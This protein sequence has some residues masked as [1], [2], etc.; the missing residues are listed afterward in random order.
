MN[1]RTRRL[2]RDESGDRGVVPGEQVFGIGPPA[3]NVI[4]AGVEGEDVRSQGVGRRDL[5]GNHLVKEFAA[6]GE[7]RVGDRSRQSGRDAIGP[8]QVLTV[9]AGLIA[10]TFG[11][12]VAETYASASDPR[13]VVLHLRRTARSGQPARLH[14]ARTS[15][16]Y[17]S[18]ATRWPSSPSPR[19]PCRSRL[20]PPPVRQPPARVDGSCDAGG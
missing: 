17:R 11:E 6:N 14:P 18:P 9:R 2:R 13:S 16:R 4:A 15:G 8:A 19:W 7:V 12:R 3:Q 1:T 5:L 10:Q 20:W